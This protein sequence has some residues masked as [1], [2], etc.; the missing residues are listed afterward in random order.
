MGLFSKA[1]DDVEGH[2]EPGK[3][4]EGEAGGAAGA[5]G[6]K[7][8]KA[9]SQR[10]EMHIAVI[11][12][13]VALILTFILYERSKNSSS[14]S[15]TTPT[16]TTG[17]TAASGTAVDPNAEQGVQQL[18]QAFNSEASQESSDVGGLTTNLNAL[19][20]QLGA[21]QAANSA[22]QQGFAGLLATLG[23][24]V[25]NI[26]STPAATPAYAPPA[27]ST[28]L[29][30][31]EAGVIP[32]L[33]A[34]IQQQIIAAGEHIV[35]ALSNNQG[36]ADFLTNTGAIYTSGNAQYQ[37]SYNAEAQSVQ[38]QPAG[39]FVGLSAGPNN[40][41]VETAASGATYAYGPGDFNF[42]T[43]KDTA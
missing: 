14:S 3:A 1:E 12:G 25:T 19:T 43:G 40:S 26:A 10:H 31:S 15:T 24:E 28:G 42:S 29:P 36:G 16:S 2:H 13:I 23:S 33:S 21:D 17:T 37:G 32:P 8:K 18:G 27:T 6:A 7:G 41:Y 20:A 11:I 35:G 34:S 9:L 5:E 30:N 4:P 39:S 38:V 22:A